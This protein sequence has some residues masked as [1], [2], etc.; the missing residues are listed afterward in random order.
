MF[1]PQYFVFNGPNEVVYVASTVTCKNVFH[2]PLTITQGTVSA[3]THALVDSGAFSCFV[4]SD[5]VRKHNL[6]TTKLRKAV[7]VFN[8]D[9]TQ[10]K[11]G[12]I[13]DFVLC[14][15]TIGHH[16]SQQPF[17]VTNIGCQHAI[18]GM[19]FLQRHNPEINWKEGT[20]EFT[21]CPAPCQPS[22]MSAQDEDL[23]GL[24][25]PHFEDLEANFLGTPIADDTWDD[26][27]RFIQWVSLPQDPDKDL[28]GALHILGIDT[29]PNSLPDTAIKP[30]ENDKDYWSA[31][32][33]S[34]YHEFGD[35]FS[36]TASERMPTR[37]PYDHAIELLPGS[38]LPRPA[39]QY[40]MTAPER[41]TLDEWIDDNLRK[42]Y[43]CESKSPT[44][45]PV[46]F[47]D[48]K[49]GSLRLVQDYQPLNAITK[50]N[51]FPIPRISELV[52]RLATATIFT[53]L[54]L[55]WGYNNVRIR[56]GD[57]EKAAFITHRGLFEPTVMFFGLCNAPATFQAM[58]NDALGDFIRGGQVI[59]YLDDI[60]IFGT[61]LT[62]H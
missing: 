37:K 40:P 13:T 6:K 2:L 51:R 8:A 44:A 21:R 9:A 16:H 54:D 29:K 30:G 14:N 55:R 59:V 48:K 1:S 35:V 26:Q 11:F 31:F 25:L 62:E 10:N 45:A 22:D 38:A 19:S 56:E 28:E 46:F 27:E 39:K 20:L 58:M 61:D 4:H 3:R 17:L 12:E 50:K 33:P 7:R 43:I 15:I 47:V 34:R 52:D 23:D 5:F 57:E 41:N 42:G 32:V 53:K 36:K 60:L 49:D 18:L 24:H